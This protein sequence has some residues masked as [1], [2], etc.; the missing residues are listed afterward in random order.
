MFPRLPP[1]SDVVEQEAAVVVHRQ[2]LHL[3]RDDA[4]TTVKVLADRQCR[5][6]G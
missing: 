5:G 4:E 6:V 1:P 3:Q 2:V